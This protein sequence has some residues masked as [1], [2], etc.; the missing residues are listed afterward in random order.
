MNGA[1][2]NLGWGLAAA[3]LVLVG[4]AVVVS[5]V[6]G[7]SVSRGHCRW[8]LCARCFQLALV[9]TIIVA[10]VRSWW[11]TVAFVLRCS[12]SRPGPPPAA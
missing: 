10:V 5:L 1:S 2:V 3:L 4:V 8:R 12:A 9:A 6:W 11:L 7:A